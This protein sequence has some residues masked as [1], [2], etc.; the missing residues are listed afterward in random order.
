MNAHRKGFKAG[1]ETM[2][3]SPTNTVG[4]WPLLSTGTSGCASLHGELERQLRQSNLISGK[5]PP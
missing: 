1:S 2:K 3:R 4:T 5:I